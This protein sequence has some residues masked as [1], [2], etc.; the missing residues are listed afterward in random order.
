[1]INNFKT[2]LDELAIIAIK[3][4]NTIELRTGKRPKWKNKIKNKEIKEKFTNEGRLIPGIKPRSSNDR[5]ESEW[6]Y[7]LIWREFDPD[8][9]FIGVK[10][11]MEIELSDMKENGLIYDY[12]KLLQS[13]AEYKIF[14]F[15][16]KTV[17]NAEMLFN[18]FESCTKNYKN[19]IESTF[20]LSCW[21]WDTSTFLFKDFKVKPKI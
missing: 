21:C 14:I 7:D 11:V 9:H 19:K 2:W 4:K 10:L 8:N 18:K 5:K 13:D 1:L 6:L 12:N 16:Q 17:S 3:R 20:F 15:Q